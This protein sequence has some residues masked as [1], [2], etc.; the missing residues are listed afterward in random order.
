MGTFFFLVLEFYGWLALV[1][2]F[3]RFFSFDT[4]TAPCF[5]L[6]IN[7][8]QQ[9]QQQ[10]RDMTSTR[11]TF[12]FFFFSPSFF[13]PLLPFSSTLYYLVFYI[14]TITCLLVS[15]PVYLF[16]YFTHNLLLLLSMYF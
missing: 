11:T 3:I 7:N 8:G 1:E 5:F 9:Q 16:V 12:S 4:T 6:S 14:C 15:F 10:K 2:T 13:S